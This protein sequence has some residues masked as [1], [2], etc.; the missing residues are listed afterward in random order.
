MIEP[1]NNFFNLTN[2]QIAEDWL[3]TK[4]INPEGVNL[5]SYKELYENDVIEVLKGE[6]LKV[7]EKIIDSLQQ[8]L[9]TCWENKDDVQL[10]EGWKLFEVSKRSRI[11]SNNSVHIFKICISPPTDYANHDAHT[12]R[13]PKGKEIKKIIQSGNYQ[14]LD[15][16]NEE[17]LAMKSEEEIKKVSDAPCYFIVKS[18]KIDL[19]DEEQT[20]EKIKNYKKEKQVKIAH[21][22]MQILVESPLVDFGYHNIHLK[23]KTGLNKKTGRLV[24]VDTEPLYFSMVRS[25]PREAIIEKI[26][27]LQIEKKSLNQR[28]KLG[29]EVDLSSISSVHDKIEALKKKLSTLYKAKRKFC[30]LK[31]IANFET[32]SQEIPV[33]LK[34]AQIYKELLKKW[35]EE[36]A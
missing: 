25:K 35:Q 21:E 10:P 30:I 7:F 36:K 23:K 22:I 18:K 27:K 33:F 28:K 12:L 32:S 9:F 15:V 2:K 19:F 11:V 13:V 16:V 6:K 24:I 29:E 14:Y 1:N 34:I 3:R 8:Q 4:D 31:G 20:I 5:Y 17:I 26:K